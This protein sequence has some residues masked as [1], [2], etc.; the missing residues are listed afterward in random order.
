MKANVNIKRLICI[1]I[2]CVIAIMGIL[3]AISNYALNIACLPDSPRRNNLDM[4]M[5]EVFGRYPDMRQWRDSLLENELWRDT[6][7]VANDG[8]KRH[9]YI[10]TH[11]EDDSIPG[12]TV[13]VHGYCD[14]SARMMRYYYLHYEML[15]RNCL[16]PDLYGH[17][18]SEGEDVRF[19]WLDR[20]DV[21]NIWLPMAHN[22]W[23]DL[24]I[25]QHG[26]SMGGATT[27]M[28]SGEDIP[29]SLRLIGFIEDCGYNNTYELLCNKMSEEV[30]LPAFPFM[31]I[32]NWLCELRFGWK[33]S[34]ADAQKQLAK[35]KHPMLFIHGDADTYVPFYMLE[36]NYNA[37]T[38]GYKEMWI[39]PGSEHAE[40]IH[41]HWEEYISRVS[42]YIQRI[43]L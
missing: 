38:Q 2:V 35:C 42:A 43:E 24:N 22:L 19:G 28:T 23:P 29:D 1:G 3:V 33:M 34:D 37:K 6:F 12:A 9:A 4:C 5:E 18:K 40:S 15:H 25:V 14:N 39:A 20:L 16:V 36:K 17:G 7:I 27:M 31:N 8:L 11:N 26:L 13:M 10:L 32:T 21:A 41:D 30:G